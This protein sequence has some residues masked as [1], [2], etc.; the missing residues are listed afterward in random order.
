[1]STEL[2]EKKSLTAIQHNMDIYEYHAHPAI[3]N[4]G[5]SLI[6]KCPRYYQYEKYESDPEERE[7]KKRHFVIGTAYHALLMEKE[8]FKQRFFIWSGAPKNTKEG[9]ADYAQAEIEAAGR[10]LL[11]QQEMDEVIA[12]A[13]AT[14]ADKSA[15]RYIG[16]DGGVVEA[17]IFW[18]DP[19][20]GVQ[21]RCRPD[22]I[23]PDLDIIVDFKTVADA[24]EE[25][26]G[27]A[28]FNY[29]YDRQAY[30]YSKGYEAAT[31]RQVKK[32]VFIT[33]EKKPPYLVGVYPISEVAL[34]SGQMRTEK[35]L[36]NYADCL[37]SNIWPGL[38]EGQEKEISIPS[39]AAY[40]ME[41][42]GSEGVSA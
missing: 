38:N 20:N 27:R 26:F 31:G 9:K 25:A 24:S 7:E 17:S 11:K 23:F 21:C 3:S 30:F 15:L 41:Q 28:I 10:I 8:L 12:L 19:V 6:A 22:L 35:L 40:R 13:Q 18:D 1:M 14:V 36:E 34:L 2:I 5:L 33:P 4:S 29:G 16:M 32:F 39:W 37:K 42:Q